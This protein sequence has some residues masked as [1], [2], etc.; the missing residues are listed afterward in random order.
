MKWLGDDSNEIGNDEV[1]GNI[2]MDNGFIVRSHSAPA[3]A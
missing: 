2:G 3:P 1:M